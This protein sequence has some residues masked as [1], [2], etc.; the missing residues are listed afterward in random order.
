[1]D[2]FMNRRKEFEKINSTNNDERVCDTCGDSAYYYYSTPRHKTDLCKDCMS[3]LHKTPEKI[4]IPY[5]GEDNCE[6]CSHVFDDEYVMKICNSILLCISCCE[7]N[8]KKALVLIKSRFITHENMNKYFYTDYDVMM[9]KIGDYNLDIHSDFAHLITENSDINYLEE[10][11]EI[12]Y[13]CDTE[14]LKWT[15]ISEMTD[16]DTYGN[17]HGLL[18]KCEYPYPVASILGTDGEH[19]ISNIVFNSYAEYVE[20]LEK[21]TISPKQEFYLNKLMD[22]NIKHTNNDFIQASS[23]FAEYVRYS[24]DI[25]KHV[26]W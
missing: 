19:S 22:D 1:M 7:N 25:R 21:W 18:V 9:K 16:F 8:Y 20:E 6:Y 4:K 17:T 24:K 3:L 23:T 11:S 10:L 26:G 13:T 15:Y 5:I 12:V 2:A 14:P